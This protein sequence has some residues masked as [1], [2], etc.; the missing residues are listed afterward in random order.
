MPQPKMVSS[1]M[2]GF[3]LG[4]CNTWSLG[5]TVWD[6]GFHVYGLAFRFYGLGFRFYGLGFITLKL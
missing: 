3:F 5:F 6:L 1:F 2:E 4:E